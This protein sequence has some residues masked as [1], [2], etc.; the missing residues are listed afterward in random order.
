MNWWKDKQVAG[1][2]KK[3]VKVPVARW[4][5]AAGERSVEKSPTT[6]TRKPLESEGGSLLASTEW[7]SLGPESIVAGNA[8][9]RLLGQN[10]NSALSR[11]TNREKFFPSAQVHALTSRTGKMPP[12]GNRVSKQ[13]KE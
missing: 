13:T 11:E 4:A 1:T 2:Q 10:D 5:R 12:A 7:Y 6:N 9:K 3:A 8:D